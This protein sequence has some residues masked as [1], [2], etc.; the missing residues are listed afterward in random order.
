MR[1]AEIWE[2]ICFIWAV[3]TVIGF[4]KDAFGPSEKSKQR[5]AVCEV[6]GGAIGRTVIIG[7]YAAGPSGT[8]APAEKQLVFSWLNSRINDLKDEYQSDVRKE[9]DKVVSAAGSRVS[10]Q[11]MARAAAAIPAEL[12][13]M[14][15]DA[16]QLAFKVVAADGVLAP[17]EYQALLSIQRALGITDSRFRD[18]YDI[19]LSSLRREGTSSTS[20]TIDELGVNP[21]WSKDQKLEHLTKE[22]AK[23]SNRMQSAKDQAQRD[24]CKRMLDLITRARE[25][26]LGTAKPVNHDEVLIGIESSLSLDEKRALLAKEEERWLARQQ[27]TKK[28]EALQACREALQAIERLRALYARTS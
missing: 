6:M 24:Y 22:F 14:R 11:D 21:A 2:V 17:A 25:Q 5:A 23:Y 4:L 13:S 27:I 19:H 7:M 16:M 3:A 9:A 12:G 8:P 18:L 28:P 26:L 10:E 15:Q 20:A 1:T